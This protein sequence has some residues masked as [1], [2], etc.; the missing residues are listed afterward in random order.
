MKGF[1]DNVSP[2]S[3]MLGDEASWRENLVK[4]THNSVNASDQRPANLPAGLILIV[5]EVVHRIHQKAEQATVDGLGQEIPVKFGHLYR[6]SSRDHLSWG[7][8]QRGR[9]HE[10]QS[11]ARPT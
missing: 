6:I 10:R 7:G 11:W 2:G 4:V 1:K 3:L 5:E 8:G 9:R